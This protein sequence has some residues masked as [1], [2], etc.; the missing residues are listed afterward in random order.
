MFMKIKIFTIALAVIILTNYQLFASV[1]LT[2]NTD[3][4]RLSLQNLYQYHFDIASFNQLPIHYYL[5][6]GKPEDH[7]QEIYFH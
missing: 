6:I 4:Q 2:A 5:S 1:C 3:L 7:F